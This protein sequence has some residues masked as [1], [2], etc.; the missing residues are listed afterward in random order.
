MGAI[1]VLGILP[2]AIYRFARGDL[3]AGVIETGIMLGISAASIYAWR[4]G[5]T[6]VAAWLITIVTLTGCVAIA[7]VLGR[8]GLLWMYAAVLAAFLMLRHSEA[9]LMSLAA[10]GAVVLHGG[11]FASTFELSMFL[12][13]S[14][15][16]A[17]FAFI[18][19]YRAEQMRGQLQSLA[20][21]DALTGA[22]NRRA[23]EEE[24]PLAIE[25]ARRTQRPCGLALIDLDHFKRINDRHGHAAGDK[26]LVEFVRLLRTATR[27]G[28]RLFRYG[29]EEFVLLLPGA[30]AAA[31]QMILDS[32]RVRI[33][34]TLL[35]A[36][37]A[38]TSSMGAAELGPDELPGS[39]LHRADVALYQAKNN[40]RDCVVVAGSAS[41]QAVQ[42]A[43]SECSG[44]SKD[45]RSRVNG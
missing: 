9:A 30:D 12:V 16:V 5:R 3:L 38:I 6:R 4:S 44:L 25:T 37:E 31:L 24:I 28:D 11:A 8:P 20:T 35:C 45:S 10:L 7:I 14:L 18:F 34:E 15:V 26:C 22:S 36:G 29:G 40:G 39:W 17:L 33:R 41:A 27:K 21:R 2:F 19:A 32:L 1:G 13:T 23:M 42:P 43:A